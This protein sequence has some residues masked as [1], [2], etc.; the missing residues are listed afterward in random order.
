MLM[1]EFWNY[2]LLWHMVCSIQCEIVFLIFHSLDSIAFCSLER[3]RRCCGD[4]LEERSS[5]QL[6]RCKTLVTVTLHWHG[7]L[8]EIINVWLGVEM[9]F[10]LL[11]NSFSTEWSISFH[12]LFM[13]FYI[14][15]YFSWKFLSNFFP[16]SSHYRLLRKFSKWHQQTL[17]SLRK[18]EW[19]FSKRKRVENKRM[20]YDWKECILK[21]LWWHYRQ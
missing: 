3:E 9:T 16:W 13:V 12:I 15:L 1:D 2:N 19:A 7:D 14:T 17:T 18:R 21:V 8:T 4:S 11:F 20:L 6:K 10:P 5:Y